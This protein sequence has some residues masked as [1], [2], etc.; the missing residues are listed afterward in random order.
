[1]EQIKTIKNR[2]MA[3]ALFMLVSVSAALAQAQTTKHI[4]E[5]GETLETIAQKYGVTKDDIVKLNPDAAQFVYVGMELTVPQKTRERREN[6][7]QVGTTYERTAPTTYTSMGTS[8]SEKIDA[9][10]FS[11][12][13]IGYRASFED[14]GHGAYTLGGSFYSPSSPHT[15]GG[16]IILGANYGLVDS[17][18]ASIYFII[19]PAYGYVI[20]KSIMLTASL[21]FVGA[22]T[23]SSSP[24]V[25][26]TDKGNSY[27]TKETDL[28]FS[29]GLSLTPRVIFKINKIKPF[30]G[31]DF[32]WNK[33]AK[34]ITA[35]FYV[36]LGFNI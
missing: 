29:W 23:S 34:E 13:G 2:I 35:G 24:V 22:Y 5:R 6:A 7:N 21:D 12:Y 19:G 1:M 11:H 10:E 3:I 30:L 4:V 25:K 15:W 18:F 8:Y 9:S 33:D 27:T 28:H 32:Q 31:L 16:D 14:A 36:G 20:N 26:T 17:D